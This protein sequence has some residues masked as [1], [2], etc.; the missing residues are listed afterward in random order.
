MR[1][2]TPAL[3]TQVSSVG[4]ISSTSG[5]ILRAFLTAR[6]SLLLLRLAALAGGLALRFDF[7]EGL[8]LAV[9][10]EEEV[11]GPPEETW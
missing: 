6:R 9:R 1:T 2:T 10:G 4:L 5:P 8:L 7:S 11:G 3:T